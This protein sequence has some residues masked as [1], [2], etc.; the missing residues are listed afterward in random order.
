MPKFTVIIP[1][2]NDLET[3]PRVLE[4]VLAQ[5]F[6]DFEVVVVNDGGTSPRE[7]LDLSAP[8][9]R[10]LELDR[11]QGVSAARNQAFAE[12]TG[13]IVYFLDADDYVAPDLLSFV[14]GKMADGEID[15]LCV[16]P[17]PVHTDEIEANLHRLDPV[18]RTGAVRHLDP[19]T[20]FEMLWRQTPLFV[21]SL[22]FHRRAALV[23]R[24]GSGPWDANLRNA[25]DLMLMTTMGAA[26]GVHLAEDS[27]VI[28]NERPASLSSDPM[29][30]WKARIVMTDK[31]IGQLRA[32]GADPKLIDV[33][34]RM[35]QN[36][37]RRTA[38]LQPDA[39]STRRVLLED[40]SASFNWR[41]AVELVRGHF[42]SR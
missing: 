13:E 12:T 29:R 24:C 31:K 28:Y 9:A 11:N 15:T 3:L 17:I 18:P 20:F 37:A 41:S 8:R 40:L 16:G 36:A 25:A 27:L 19:V 4:M 32:A 38:R 21:P 5:D 33:V 2:F 1:T 23:E 10:L 35:R 6:Q 14:A 26:N 39:A 34:R 22:V 30:T 7:V 42:R